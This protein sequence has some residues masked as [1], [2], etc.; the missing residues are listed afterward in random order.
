MVGCVLIHGFTGSPFELEPLS[1]FLEKKGIA[2]SVPVLAGHEG[3]KESMR[4]VTW[5]D[6]IRSAEKA[7]KEM[8]AKC[9]TVYLIGFSMG[10]LIA[11]HLSTKY[12]VK[13]L[14]MMSACVFYV[15]PQQLFKDVAEVIKQHFKEGGNP[16]H[17]KRY[18]DKVSK[19]PLRS[20]VH[21]RRL[22]KILKQDLPKV[23]VPTLILQ[24]EC[25]DL[26]EPRSAQY[27]YDTIQSEIKEIYFL[28]QSR[29][30][31]CH[32]CEKEEVIR[33]VDQFLFPFTR[34]DQ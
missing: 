6:W 31:I 33:R 12:P 28:P 2:I 7:V 16:E 14:V 25:D 29:H 5:Q 32:D 27:I 22:V 26:V 10:G 19:T 11:A 24:G 9:D 20:V 15:N 18:I 13:K 23:T 1:A 17:F 34:V 8:T 21:F 3:S 30:I 4:D